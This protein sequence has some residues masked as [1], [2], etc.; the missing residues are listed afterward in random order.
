[1]RKSI[2]LGLLLAIAGIMA[3][4]CSSCQPGKQKQDESVKTEALYYDYDGVVQ[5]FF[6][7]VSNIQALHRTT[8]YALIGSGEYEWRNSQVLLS[9]VITAETIDELYVTDI[10]DVFYYWQ[11]G[12]WVQFV[13]SNID[14]GLQVPW[15]IRDVWIEDANLS[16]CEIRLGAEDVLKKLKEWNGLIPDG[17]RSLTLRLPVG[18][19]VCNAQ[20]VIGNIGDVI[21][22]DAVT[23]DITNWNPA[24]NPS[25]KPKGGDFGKPLG[26]WP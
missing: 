18:P 2:L 26:E 8:M 17:A 5:D 23:G 25:N 4:G 19:M 10:N 16:Q 15:P 20:W 14:Q 13:N 21:F 6:A 11:D 1:M 7:G 22:V 9:D 3:T 24:F 12:P